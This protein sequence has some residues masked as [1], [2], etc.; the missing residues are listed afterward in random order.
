[1]CEIASKAAKF[2]IVATTH[3]FKRQGVTI[4]WFCLAETCKIKTNAESLKK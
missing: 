2:L 1:M 3:V 4:T